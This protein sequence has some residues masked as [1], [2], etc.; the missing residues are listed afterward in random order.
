MRRNRRL[1]LASLLWFFAV[2]ALAKTRGRQ[3]QR[4]SRHKPKRDRPS[5]PARKDPPSCA[6]R[7]C[8]TAHGSRQARSTAYSATTC[9][10]PCSRSSTPMDSKRPDGSTPGRGR[11]WARGSGLTTY[12]IT[13]AD[14][15]GPFAKIPADMMQRAAMPYSRLRVARRSAGGKI[16]CEPDVAARDESWPKIRRGRR[17]GR[18]RRGGHQAHSARLRPSR[19]SSHCTCCSSTIAKGS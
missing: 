6:P 16:P 5:R 4:R 7:R 18:P 8:W 1:W 9:V 12:R 3:R 19:S 13:E 11:R 17:L 15:A 10:K 14:V 2:P